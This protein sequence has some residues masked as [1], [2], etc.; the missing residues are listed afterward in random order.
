MGLGFL[1]LCWVFY[2]FVFL[3]FC[4]VFFCL[5]QFYY[6]KMNHRRMLKNCNR[7]NHITGETGRSLGEGTACI[8]GVMLQPWNYLTVVMDGSD[9]SWM[10]NWP[11][12]IPVAALKEDLTVQV[13]SLQFKFKLSFETVIF[14]YI[15]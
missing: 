12:C 13:V 9:L 11:Q 2:V 6:R 5:I 4:W 1:V 14:V 8:S 3:L 7:V 10:E 15:I